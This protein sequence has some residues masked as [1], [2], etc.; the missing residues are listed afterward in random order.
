MNAIV[1][2]PIVRHGALAAGLVAALILLVVFHS[3][4]AGAVQRAAQHRSDVMAEAVALR[5]A[6]GPGAMQPAYFK[7]RRVSLA[8]AAD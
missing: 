7:T 4:V 8:R 3:V 2:T 6:A 1:A 5:T